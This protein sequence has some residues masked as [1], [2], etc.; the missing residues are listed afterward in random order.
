MVSEKNITIMPEQQI[1]IATWNLCLGLLNKRD[2]IKMLLNT[3]QIHLLNMQ[4]TEIPPC[5]DEA[6]LNIPGYSLEVEI[7]SESKRVTNH[8][9]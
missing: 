9:K 2:Y 7:N 5:Q 6:G 3:E 1:K 8:I 4:E